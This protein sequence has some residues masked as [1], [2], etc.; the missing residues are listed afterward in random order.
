MCEDC[1]WRIVKFI[2]VVINLIFL[3]LGLLMLAFGIAMVANP[4]KMVSS[5]EGTGVNL[6]I[7][8]DTSTIFHTIQQIG[9]FMIVIGAIAAVVGFFG[10]FGACCENK[11]LLVMYLICMIISLLCEIALIIF[12]ACFPSPFEK[13]VQDAMNKTLIHNFNQDAAIY[14]NFT[15]GGD[16]DGISWASTQFG[17]GCCGVYS[18][19]D[20]YTYLPMWA[21]TVR[22]DA[23][24]NYT[25]A[26]YPISCCSL[27]GGPGNF[28]PKGSSSSSSSPFVD[29]KG[30]LSNGTMTS[31]YNFK[32][33]VN[34]NNCYVGFENLIL[35]YSK[36]AIGIAAAIA[37]FLVILIILGFCL[38]CHLHKSKSQA[39]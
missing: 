3:L 34:Q 7:L 22:L 38:C 35:Q 24:T 11:C 30:C 19:N 5:I 25:N 13:T 37:G 23:N 27:V 29:L 28:P 16:A 21:R 26:T 18:P 14:P 31:G 15:L 33:A 8:G 36:I 4:E 20:Y 17:V 39:I 9:I 6:S 1:G 12:A 10:F 2:L 32:A